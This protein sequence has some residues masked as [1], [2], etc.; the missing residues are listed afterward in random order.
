MHLATLPAAAVSNKKINGIV[1][2]SLSISIYQVRTSATLP[3][4]KKRTI[5]NY[6]KFYHFEFVF[7][8]LC[9]C[10]LQFN[11]K[12]GVP[13]VPFFLASKLV[14]GKI[15][16]RNPDFCMF[17]QFFFPMVLRLKHMVFT[18]KISE[19]TIKLCFFFS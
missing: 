11:K 12:E 8:V 1:R 4:K 15:E 5:Y 7:F 19:F 13:T 16:A 17:L 2:T 3:T 9:S 6:I 10:Q 14:Q 18:I